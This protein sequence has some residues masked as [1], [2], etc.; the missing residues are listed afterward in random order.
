VIRG[1]IRHDDAVLWWLRQNVVLFADDA[2]LARH[3]GLG[4]PAPGPLSIIHPDF[5]GLRRRPLQELQKLHAV[6]GDGGTFRVVKR[7]NGGLG[8]TRLPD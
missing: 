8:I 5:S 7:P 2:T 6:F 1:A 3:P 4:A